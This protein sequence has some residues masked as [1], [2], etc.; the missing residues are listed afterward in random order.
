MLGS[1]K[2]ATLKGY[3]FL[4]GGLRAYASQPISV[5]DTSPELKK[6]TNFE[7]SRLSAGGVTGP[8]KIP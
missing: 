1:I 2:C 5:F 3:E 4:S 8:F 7:E 6:N